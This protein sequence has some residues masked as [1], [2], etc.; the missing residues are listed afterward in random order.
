MIYSS[1]KNW[2][3]LVALF[4]L[5]AIKS[6][7]QVF[8][9]GYFTMDG[10]QTEGYI[11]F[12][13]MS[14]MESILFSYDKKGKQATFQASDIS[15]FY[16]HEHQAEFVSVT[17][18]ATGKQLFTE[19]L[20]KG[21]ATYS[22]LN[23]FHV[24][25]MEDQT[26]QIYFPLSKS[27][28]GEQVELADV[29]RTQIRLI[30]TLKDAFKDCLLPDFERAMMPLTNDKVMKAV[31]HFNACGGQ[32]MR[33][34]KLV[35]RPGIVA[36]Y[37][38]SKVKF[39]DSRFDYFTGQASPM[40]GLDLNMVPSRF[41]KRAI[42]NLQLLFWQS[43]Y[44][45]DDTSPLAP[46]NID[47]DHSTLRMPVSVKLFLAPGR[48]GFFVNPGIAPVLAFGGETNTVLVEIENFSIGGF[49]GVGYEQPVGIHQR[50]FGGVRF[51]SSIK[52]PFSRGANQLNI[53]FNAGYRF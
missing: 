1:C 6:P 28:S 30:A 21:D 32:V 4:I 51:E 11:G 53:Q 46:L 25:T 7:A 12:P 45:L 9:K 50:I 16:L 24:I 20:L 10:A 5:L 40:V 43:K 39:N 22:S 18:K 44:T 8:Y 27:A 42:F 52:S 17:E 37:Q 13:S 38:L 2:V 26:I 19:V 15:G 31:K 29:Q 49:A 3:A 23:N 34:K 36:G 35:M 48:H 47:L 41:F 33:R 14:S